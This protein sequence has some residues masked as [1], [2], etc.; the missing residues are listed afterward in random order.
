MWKEFTKGIR[1]ENPV[2]VLLLGLCPVMALSQ[3]FVNALVMGAVVLIVLP[4]SGIV[5]SLCR[6][7]I[8]EKVRPLFRLFVVSVF[9]TMLSLLLQTFTPSL[10]DRL[11]IFLPLVAVNCLIIARGGEYAGT[12]GVF[13]TIFDSL[14]MGAGFTLAFCLIALLRE[15]LGSG[16]ITLW[17]MNIPGLEDGIL[18]IPGLAAAPVAALAAPAGALIV[19]GLLKGLFNAGGSIRKRIVADARAF[20]ALFDRTRDADQRKGGRA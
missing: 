13:P 11:G 9:V 7:I 18:E 3:R 5:I 10:A 2:F 8:P 17:P 16:S 14:G 15:T 19:F 6:N 1:R 12:H 4:F 20:L